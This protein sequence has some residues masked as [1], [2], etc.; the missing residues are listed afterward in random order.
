MEYYQGLLWCLHCCVYLHYFFSSKTCSCI[1][2]APGTG[3]RLISYLRI[4]RSILICLVPYGLLIFS[5]LPPLTLIFPFSLYPPSPVHISSS[6]SI[7]MMA[8]K[9]LLLLPSGPKHVSPQ[10]KKETWRSDGCCGTQSIDRR[11][12]GAPRSSSKRKNPKHCNLKC[13]HFVM[14]SFLFSHTQSY[15]C[16][17]S[18]LPG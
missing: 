2:C 6:P 15:R 12:F 5:P 17:G 1:P 4:G 8:L 14:I 18:G 9:D 16:S 13:S 10:I 11:V 7:I 3:S